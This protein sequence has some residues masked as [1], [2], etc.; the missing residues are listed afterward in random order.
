MAHRPA[1]S[2]QLIPSSTVARHREPVTIGVP[3]PRGL[4]VD[5]QELALFDD[6]GS[7]HPLQAHSLE[8]WSDGSLRWVLLDFQADAPAGQPVEYHVG[9]QRSAAAASG[10][11]QVQ[12]STDC[13]IVRNNRLAISCGPG[14]RFPLRDVTLDGRPVLDVGQS[15]CVV[16]SGGELAEV[17]FHRVEVD[18]EGSIRTAIVAHGIARTRDMATLRLTV[19]IEVFASH[20]CLRVQIVL[21][22]PRRAHHPGNFW[23]LGDAGSVDLDCVTLSMAPSTHPIT[24]VRCSL[25][26]DAP[27]ETMAMPLRVHQE[28]SGKERWKSRVHVDKR[29]EVPMILR[30]YELA[31]GDHE[32]HGSHASP[33]VQCTAGTVQLG[34]AAERFW[35]LFP[36]SYEVRDERLDIGVLPKTGATYELQGGERLSHRFVLSLDVDHVTELP[37]EWCRLP[38]VP[39][40]AP[41]WAAGAHAV[42]HLEAVADRELVYEQLV[43]AAIE[44][45]A[46]FESKRDQIDEYGWRHF[47]DLY[48]DHENGTRPDA[49]LLVSH[50]NNQYDAIGGLLV[51]HMRSGDVRWR[52]LADDLATHVTHIDIYWTDEDKSAYSGGMFWHTAHYVDAGRSTHRSYPVAPGVPGG[53]PSAEHNYSTGLLLHHLMTGDPFSREAVLRLARWTIDMDDGRKTPLKLLAPVPTGTGSATGSTAYHGPGRGP[54]NGIQTLF[55]ALRLT[56]ERTYLD[57]AET[58]IRRCIHPS[59]DVEARNLLDAERRWYYTV[60]LQALGRHLQIKEERNERDAMWQ[61]SR[62]SLLHYARWMVTHEYPIL[63]KPEALEYPTETWAAQDMRKCE[64]FDLASKYAVDEVERERF[65]ERARFFFEVS[66]RTLSSMPTHVWTRPTVLMLSYGHSHLWFE[67]HRAD[68]PLLGALGGTDFGRPQAFTPQ[69]ALAVRRLILVVATG[70]L[71]GLAAVAWLVAR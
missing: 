19:R 21:H 47:G 67:A 32:R 28:S 11:V 14:A 48:A 35:E 66:T 52:R 37:L 13:L 6:K 29:G 49:P 22:N 54:A 56:G 61:Y 68:L 4:C 57:H 38:L 36:K 31:A 65:A 2:L 7:A 16:E 8:R 30:G 71:A 40:V 63:D 60:F 59:D 69:R 12:R 18:L 41:A 15:A 1:C 70:A 50:Y 64:V 27:L 25:D 3:F 62:A 10:A 58:L 51:Q 9:P 55:N 42:P 5:P 44:G 39:V 33:I 20:P 23:E 17:S 53:G 45:D 34:V 43:N 24:S 26:A 46:T